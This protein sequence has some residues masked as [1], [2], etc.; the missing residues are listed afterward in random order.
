[1]FPGWPGDDVL[2]RMRRGHEGLIDAL[3][4]E[5]RRRQKPIRYTRPSCLAAEQMQDLTSF[6][7][8]KLSPMVHGLFPRREWAPVLATLEKSIV[9][10]TPETIEDVIPDVVDLRTAWDVANAHLLGIGAE[11][12]CG[13]EQRIVGLSV[14][15]V[16][17]VS[18]AYFTE[19]DPF[20]DFVVHEAAHVFHNTKRVSI[21][22]PEIRHQEWL[23]PIA[24]RKRETFAYAIE[25]YSRIR[26]LG[27]TAAERRSLLADLVSR[28]LPADDRVDSA[29]YV[30]ILTEAIGQRNGWKAI[31]E[32]CS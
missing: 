6:A 3:V 26:E 32:R 11:P 28:P 20:A 12:L 7:R 27:Q 24:F 9:F 19:D 8:E 30:E 31:L 29:E 23:L 5:I 16:C 22:L 18:E 13:E 10:L 21:G 17:Y 4:S 15:T 2:D 1:M 14:E 25:A